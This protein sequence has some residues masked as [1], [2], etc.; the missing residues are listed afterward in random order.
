MRM[1]R[2]R[3]GLRT[4][5]DVSEQRSCTGSEASPLILKEVTDCQ[6]RYVSQTRASIVDGWIQAGF[7][8][9]TSTASE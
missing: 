5:V 8:A 3:E 1:F 7:A 2:T 6:D 9:V 4:Y